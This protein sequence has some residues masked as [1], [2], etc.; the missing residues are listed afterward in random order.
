MTS[1][2]RNNNVNNNF[3]RIAKGVGKMASILKNFENNYEQTFPKTAYTKMMIM[4]ILG[5]DPSHDYLKINRYT[6]DQQK[7]IGSNL[8]EL[9]KF[10]INR[11]HTLQGGQKGGDPQYLNS[12][13]TN[14]QIQEYAEKISDNFAESIIVNIFTD[15]ITIPLIFQN[16]M[17]MGFN[18]DGFPEEIQDAFNTIPEKMQAYNIAN[19]TDYPIAHIFKNNGF[20]NNWK[21]INW[22]SVTQE[23]LLNEIENWKIAIKTD[24]K[25]KINAILNTENIELDDKYYL[26]NL[27]KIEIWFISLK[28]N[29]TQISPDNNKFLNDILVTIES[30]KKMELGIG[31]RIKKLLAILHPDKQRFKNLINEISEFNINE[32]ENYSTHLQCLIY[33]NHNYS[34]IKLQKDIYHDDDNNNTNNTMDVDT[35][36]KFQNAG[37]KTKKEKKT[38]NQSKYNKRKPKS[39]NQPKYKITKNNRLLNKTLLKEAVKFIMNFCEALDYPD[40]DNIDKFNPN[41]SEIT[42]EGIDPRRRSVKMSKSNH[43]NTQH[44]DVGIIL[45][46]IQITILYTYIQHILNKQ[47]KMDFLILPEYHDVLGETDISSWYEG[48]EKFD[49]NLQNAFNIIIREYYPDNI[50]LDGSVDPLYLKKVDELDNNNQFIVN[51]AS[52]F[53]SKLEDLGFSESSYFGKYTTQ[54]I[55]DKTFCAIPSI[56]DAMSNCSFNETSNT[57]EYNWFDIDYT[58]RNEFDKKDVDK[59][60]YT[61]NV[62]YRHE[63]NGS[64]V[65]FANLSKT[66]RG[67]FELVKELKYSEK[68]LS[69]FNTYKEIIS[70][71][72]PV[73]Q[74]KM[75]EENKPHTRNNKTTLRGV[76]VELLRE[77][78][79]DIIGMFSK[80]G[81]GD[82]AQEALVTSRYTAGSK[83]SMQESGQY[84]LSPTDDDGNSIRLGVSGDRPS[85]YRMIFQLLH[86]DEDT[87]NSKAIAGYINYGIT[88]QDLNKKKNQSE[89]VIPNNWKKNFLVGPIPINNL[90]S[91][92]SKTRKNKKVKRRKT[93]R[94]KTSLPKS[95]KKTKKI[96]KKRRNKTKIKKGGNKKKYKKR[97]NK[98][99]KKKKQ[100][101]EMSIKELKKYV[102]KKSKK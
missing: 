25:N 77:I 35:D 56:L 24:Y 64:V 37:G 101:F 70:K 11:N 46:N 89:P 31:L 33:L 7:S 97:R 78:M 26:N 32:L 22:N 62:R 53:S 93:R 94:K 47:K 42:W 9:E 95:K 36:E 54:D 100:F 90:N 68:E 21:R 49:N 82:Y 3:K 41:Y 85:A 18:T 6:N 43:W 10:L 63:Q 15:V 14:E 66:G 27:N 57:S 96:K 88:K 74:K 72:L 58:I 40:K 48:P 39:K 102:N 5:Q 2:V 79:S 51:N 8:I 71:L 19:F 38:K 73:Y 81:I 34:K 50:Y 75:A 1:I 86:A 76:F 83:R 16:K 92:G 60:I 80:K 99:N 30:H 98:K 20:Y 87:I 4:N 52:P 91:G 13:Q 59:N 12:L 17:M 65:L 84:N 44:I 28:N 23:L 61:Y 55:K 45:Y 69:A 67:L 29:Y